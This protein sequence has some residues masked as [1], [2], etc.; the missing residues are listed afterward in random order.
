MEK[1]DATACCRQEPSRRFG[2]ANEESLLAASIMILSLFLVQLYL[3]IAL[4]YYLMLIQ[5]I[6]RSEFDVENTFLLCTLAAAGV[7]ITVRLILQQHISC[8]RNIQGEPR[9]RRKDV[10]NPIFSAA[11]YHREVEEEVQSKSP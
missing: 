10:V 5:L 8:Y 7:P 1:D 3:L 4:H 6:S 2:D 11:L 9:R